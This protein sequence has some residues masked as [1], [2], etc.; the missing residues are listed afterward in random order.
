MPPLPITIVFF[1]TGFAVWA[2]ALYFLGVGAKRGEGA[3]DPIRAV[4]WITLLAGLS[5]FVQAFYI[6]AAR[7]APLGPAS[8]LIAGLVIFYAGFF[9]F[10]G[11]TEVMGLD[12]RPL[13]NV[14]VGVAIVPLVYCNVFAGGWMFLSI[15]I[16]W[17]VAFLAVALTTYGR[18]A[19]R[20]LGGI[21]LVTAIYTF[22]V[23][24]SL[25]ALG[26]AIP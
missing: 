21:L 20:A 15:L 5:D 25:V 18:L 8:V 22:W 9:S 14:A 11:I 24:A 12:L 10:L 23:P 7:P 2:N 3:P 1:L 4:G 17:L 16:A 19:G 13:G 26:Q 6:M